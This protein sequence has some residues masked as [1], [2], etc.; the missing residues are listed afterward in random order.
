M[1]VVFAAWLVAG[2]L[3][4]ALTAEPAP[5]LPHRELYGRDYVDLAAW[6]RANR[7]VMQWERVTGDVRLTNRWTKLAF[8]I[9]SRRAEVNRVRAWLSAPITP[10]D[11]GAY[12]ASVDLQTLLGPVLAPSRNAPGQRVRT[13]VLDPGHGGKDPGNQVG[14]EQEKRETLLLAQEAQRVLR[15]AGLRVLLTRADDQFV[16]LGERDAIA[17]RAHADL[18]VSL[19]Y[20]ATEVRKVGVRGVEV[21]CLT[22]AGAPSTNGHG[23]DGITGALPG[24]KNDAKN[25]LLAYE[26]QAAVV[27]NLATE[28]RGVHRARFV[29]LREAA[30]PAVLIEGGFMTDPEEGRQISAA[31]HRVELARAIVEGILTYKRLVER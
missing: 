24:N 23:N 2:A 22:P 9:D 30:M 3:G 15:E 10:R 26:V 11:Q 4:A 27:R 18:F 19:H 17:R 8:T 7:L 6:A 14:H 21:Y 5:R 13:I 29:V 12:I 1:R 20:N 25:V 16:D 31:S 28:D